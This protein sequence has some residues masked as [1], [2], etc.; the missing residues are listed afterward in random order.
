M[1]RRLAN[2]QPIENAQCE[3]GEARL[4]VVPLRAG[5]GTR[6]YAYAQAVNRNTRLNNYRLPAELSGKNRKDALWGPRQL[7]RTGAPRTPRSASPAGGTRSDDVPEVGER[8]DNRQRTGADARVVLRRV[9][10]V[11]VAPVSPAGAQ[12]GGSLARHPARHRAPSVACRAARVR[13]CRAST[14]CR[15]ILP[16]RSRQTD[17]PPCGHVP[18]ARLV[19]CLKPPF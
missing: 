12:H 17:S 8:P 1:C 3:A 15:S 18:A 11:V 5:T 9:S 16:A 13:A 14:P 19:L 4:P 6:A 7:S 10:P 2:L